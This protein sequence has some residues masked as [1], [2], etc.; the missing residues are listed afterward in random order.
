[1][2]PRITKEGSFPP[3]PV[4][5]QKHERFLKELFDNLP[6]LEKE[7]SALLTKA[8]DKHNRVI[9]M[10]LNQVCTLFFFF[11][12]SKVVKRYCSSAS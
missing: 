9:I 12:S 11:K 7:A 2:I 6:S 8:A 1:M 5:R 10:A 4:N 3:L